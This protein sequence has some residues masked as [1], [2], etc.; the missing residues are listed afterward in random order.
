MDVESSCVDGEHGDSHMCSKNLCALVYKVSTPCCT[1]HYHLST[2]RW[3]A[4]VEVKEQKFFGFMLKPN[5]SINQQKFKE[6]FNG[7]WAP[8]KINYPELSWQILDKWIWNVKQLDL[9][10][11]KEGIENVLVSLSS[12]FDEFVFSYCC[13]APFKDKHSCKTKGYLSFDKW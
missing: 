8:Q 5:Q 2:S 3:F 9:D 10:L 11:T 13:C 4:T 7:T 12:F 1:E 6:H